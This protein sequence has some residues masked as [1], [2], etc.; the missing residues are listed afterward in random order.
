M[1]AKQ[2]A[3]QPLDIW[4]FL[5]QTNYKPCEEVTCMAFVCNLLLQERE[6]FEYIQLRNDPAFSERRATLTAILQ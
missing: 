3:P 2:H 6:V 1:K 4:T 5:P